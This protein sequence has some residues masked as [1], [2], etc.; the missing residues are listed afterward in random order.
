MCKYDQNVGMIYVV[1]HCYFEQLMSIQIHQD[2]AKHLC[3][4][5]PH[6]DSISMPMVK[7]YRCLMFSFPQTF[8]KETHTDNC[9]QFGEEL[10]YAI[11]YPHL[12]LVII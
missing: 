10:H 9:F 11:T 2:H 3:L 7:V 1:I 5:L 12:S 6:V 8:P 4:F